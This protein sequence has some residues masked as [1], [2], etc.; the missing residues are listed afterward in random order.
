MAAL[1]SEAEQF[2][3]TVSSAATTTKGRVFP[4]TNGSFSGNFTV[5][6]GGTYA[7]SVKYL[8]T[9]LQGSPFMLQVFATRPDPAKS[10]LLSGG[11]VAATAGTSFDVHVQPVDV[12]GNLLRPID[13]LP[14]NVFSGFLFAQGIPLV[15][16]QVKPWLNASAGLPV[17]F[18]LTVADRY[19]ATILLNNRNISG[20]PFV[21]L[22]SAGLTSALFST[23]FPTDAQQSSTAGLPFILRISAYDAVRD[24]V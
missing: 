20:S 21:I 9:H 11:V 17:T 5:T 16:Q 8:S 10:R 3:L 7:V 1:S 4:S 13:L 19:T 23:I 14:S 18:L 22:V 2:S 15:F 24:L 6:I 12:Y